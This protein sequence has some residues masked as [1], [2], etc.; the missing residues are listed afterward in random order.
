M[1]P[2]PAATTMYR[3]MAMRFWRGQAEAEMGQLQSS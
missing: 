1:S 3:E 2:W